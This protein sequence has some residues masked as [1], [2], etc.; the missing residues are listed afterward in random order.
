MKEVT[1]RRSCS[2]LVL[3]TFVA[4]AFPAGANFWDGQM[5]VRLMQADERV[6]ASRRADP[7]DDVVQAAIYKG[8]VIGV[9]DSLQSRGLVCNTSGV[10]DA[11]LRDAV[12][13]YLKTHPQE[14]DHPASNIVESALREA[15]PCPATRR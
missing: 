5:L 3:L 12:A 13:K 15:F 8:F 14:W 10:T 6:T 2:S 7:L 1:M 9:H 4:F 11:Q